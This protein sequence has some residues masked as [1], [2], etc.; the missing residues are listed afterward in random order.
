VA[1]RYAANSALHPVVVPS[2]CSSPHKGGD[3]DSATSGGVATAGGG[4]RLPS[5][6]TATK[7]AQADARSGGSLGGGRLRLRYKGMRPR[8]ALWLPTVVPIHC[9]VQ[10]CTWCLSCGWRTPT[11][12]GRW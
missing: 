2:G 9:C 11:L 7:G 5:T 12:R 8:L 6:T 1:S 3:P 4:A 10:G